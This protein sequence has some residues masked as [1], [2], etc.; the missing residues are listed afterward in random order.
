MMETMRNILSKTT[1]IVILLFFIPDYLLWGQAGG[2]RNDI[3]IPG[4]LYM[5]SDARNDI[6]V[7]ALIKRWR[8]YD[9]Y[10]RF[11]GDCIFSRKLDRMASIDTPKNGTHLKIELVNSDEFE[12]IKEDTLSICVGKRGVGTGEVT[13]QILGDSFVNGAFFKDAL[14][15]KNYV[16]GA[17]LIGLRNIK[18]VEGQYDE[19]RGGWTVKKYFE[20]PKGERIS[21][22]GY[23]QPVGEYKYWGSCEFWK[24][25]HKVINGTLKDTE[26]VYDCGRYDKCAMRFDTETGY[27]INP[28]KNDL[29]YDNLRGSYM[30]YTG[31][32]WKSVEVNEEEWT[33]NFGKYLNM[34]NLEA[35]KFFAQMLGLNDYRDS[36]TADY[37]EWN[38]KIA[39]MKE[40]Y[41]KAVPDGKFIILIPCSTCGSLNNIR[42]D[43]TLRQNAAMWRLR[44]NI[45][46]TF[47][48]R[49][50]EGYYL[51]DVAITIDNEKGYNLNGDGL[52]TGNPHP[53]PN[54][55]T[56]G[57]PIAAF[58]QYY[59]EQ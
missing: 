31:K 59:R 58:I 50:E 44:K 33:F 11:S 55:P 46:D 42:G 9:D 4:K 51:V 41:Y 7:E 57:I 37:R 34:W 40:S 38:E 30:A 47:D 12:T 21:Y 18:N 35:P 19:G 15:V 36:L 25:C 54:Y 6:F 43:F 13:I 52:Q 32:R 26:V 17:K 29:M 27:L 10:V 48:G 56:M 22:Q 39:E 24:N 1:L 5:L 16:P 2:F 28:K 49:E 14:L 53:Y 3:C 23:M 45:I 8:P 20:I